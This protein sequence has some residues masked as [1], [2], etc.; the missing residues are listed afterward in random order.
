[1]FGIQP[2][3]YRH[4]MPQPPQKMRFPHSLMNHNQHRHC[5][6]GKVTL[7]QPATSNPFVDEPPT[8]IGIIVSSIM[9]I[10]I[11]CAWLIR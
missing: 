3:N 11:I 7:K 4:Y 6:I 5:R 8:G 10:G 2:P 1:M 9:L